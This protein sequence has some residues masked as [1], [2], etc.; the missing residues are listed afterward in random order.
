MKIDAQELESLAA[1]QPRM[2]MYSGIHKA[3]RACMADTLVALGRVDVDDLAELEA[4]IARVTALMDFC[5]SHLRHENEHVHRAI[6]ARA[7][8]AAE[9]VAHDHEEH[10]AHIARLRELARLLQQGRPAVRPAAAQQ[11]YRELSLFVA[12]NLRHMHVEETAHNAVLWARYTDAELVA[13]HDALVASIPPE[14]MMGISRWMLPA[15]NPAERL[16]LLADI[17]SKVPPEALQ[18]MLDVVRPHLDEREWAHVC[19]GLGLPPA[20]GLVAA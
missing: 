19:R 11:L 5:E 12:E 15:M 13:I 18:A 14:E 10:A 20:P 9:A 7:P 6:E 2:D 17:Q 16:M 1:A 3:V 8:G 4:G